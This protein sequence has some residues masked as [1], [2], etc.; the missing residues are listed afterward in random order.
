V[1]VNYESALHVAFATRAH[2]PYHVCDHVTVC[3]LA[4]T[5]LL[6]WTRRELLAIGSLDG[7]TEASRQSRVC[8]GVGNAVSCA[9]FRVLAEVRRDC[10][11]S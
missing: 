4:P 6:K 5:A 7:L 11:C 9:V 10:S 2:K 1:H 3:F 8:A